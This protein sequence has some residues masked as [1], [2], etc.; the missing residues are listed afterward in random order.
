[1]IRASAYNFRLKRPKKQATGHPKNTPTC[2]TGTAMA[3]R[4]GR[5]SR[6][7]GNKEKD[8]KEK[9]EEKEKDKDT[10]RTSKLATA[11]FS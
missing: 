8:E 3:K 7:V 9:D 2:A 1:M 4:R 5:N 11:F 10:D 6:G